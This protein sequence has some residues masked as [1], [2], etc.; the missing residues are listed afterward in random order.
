MNR[1]REQN[2]NVVMSRTLFR[3]EGSR[4]QGQLIS[5]E[6]LPQKFFQGRRKAFSGFQSTDCFYSFF[7]FSLCLPVLRFPAA[8]AYEL[9]GMRAECGW[10]GGGMS[11]A[12]PRVQMFVS[13]VS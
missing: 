10:M 1:I 3:A 2:F 5:T 12:A 9:R 6:R 11:V 8:S 13:A 7:Y 4:S